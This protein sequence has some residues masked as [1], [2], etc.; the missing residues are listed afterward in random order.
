MYVYIG[1]Y[2][3][4]FYAF[5]ILYFHTHTPIYICIYTRKQ[6]HNY[7]LATYGAYDVV[8]VADYVKLYLH[9]N[10]FVT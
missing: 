7:N 8:V 5:K 3:F 2:I 10:L 1:Y 9:L 4:Y 6:Q